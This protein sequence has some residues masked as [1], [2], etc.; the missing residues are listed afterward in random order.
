M[1]FD[2]A[3]PV[4]RIAYGQS[5]RFDLQSEDRGMRQGSNGSRGAKQSVNISQDT[6]LRI[7]KARLSRA[8]HSKLA[9]NSAGRFDAEPLVGQLLSVKA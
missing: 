4:N 2:T 6:L 9:Y 7:A 3:I 5:P 8:V 1:S